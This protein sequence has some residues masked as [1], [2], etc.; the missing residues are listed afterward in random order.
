MDA[1]KLAQLLSPNGMLLFGGAHND[2]AH[3]DNNVFK[4]LARVLYCE[5]ESITMA[6]KIQETSSE[7]ISN[8]PVILV[9][10]IQTHSNGH[11]V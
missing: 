2:I 5:G 8:D 6:Q 4:L 7:P 3:W 11:V 10:W 9:S 1:A